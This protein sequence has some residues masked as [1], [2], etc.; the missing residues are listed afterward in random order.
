[1]K[2]D[3]IT[4]DPRQMN[5]QPCVR[6]LR[7][8]VKRVLQLISLYPDRREL[9]A[10]YPELDEEDIRQVLAFAAGSVDDEILAWQ[11]PHEIAA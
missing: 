6:G 4:I 9:S 1:M 11:G 3:R 2:L 10:E 7:L 5:G 8:T